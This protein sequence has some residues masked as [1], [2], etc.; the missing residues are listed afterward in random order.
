MEFLKQY[1]TTLLIILLISLLYFGLRIP[2]LTLQPI[3]ADEAIYIRWAQVMK[4]EPT[5]RFLPLSDGKTPLFMWVMA[6]LF[7]IFEDPLF[8]GRILSVFSGFLTLIGAG[9]LGWKFFNK[10]IGLWTALLI[11]IIPFTLFFDRL[12]LVDSML[13]AF[14]VWSL[15]LALFLIKYQRLDLAMFLGYIMGAGLLT[16]TPGFFS[17]LVLPVTLLA[18]PKLGKER[19]KIVLKMVGLWA[20]AIAITLVI[21]NI[22]RLGPGF[23]SLSSR[24]QDYM[25]SPLELIGRPWDP[26]LPHLGDIVDWF[27]RL[28]TWPV[29]LL[30][31]AAFVWAVLKRERVV[32]VILLW[33]LLPML[34][35]MA[36]LKT[37]TARYILFSI[38]PFLII[39]AWFM[40]KLY[41]FL[42]TKTRWAAILLI[43]LI[44][45]LPLRFDLLLLTT[46][47][48]A[49]LPHN[50]RRG[51]FEDWTAG[52][53]FKEIAQFLEV[54]AKEELVVVGTEGSFG[55]LPD[56]LQIYLDKNRQVIVIGGKA[57]ISAQLRQTATEHPTYFIANSASG[58]LIAPGIELVKEYKKVASPDGHM[59]SIQLFKVFPLKEASNSTTV[60]SE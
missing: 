59:G 48:K 51:Y 40:D 36:L 46:P 12:A 43:A 8:A 7:K 13:A 26:F 52:Y 57:T 42:R 16:K 22:L 6:P 11:A 60:V 44:G 3:F 27:K 50:E 39:A 49:P 15:N 31:G 35:E 29:F 28:L 54:R 23:V 17:V 47:E 55:T 30:V 53:G 24:N 18:L 2:N 32:L 58:L 19:Q 20:V 5:L 25:F 56:G 21:Y 9:F 37:F 45:S 41:V 10:R 34:A 33:G 14:S 38:P 1:K 4:A